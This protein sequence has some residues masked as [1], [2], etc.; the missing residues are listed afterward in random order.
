MSA[1]RTERAILPTSG[2]TVWLVVDDESLQPMPEARDFV[3][4]LVGA[5]RSENTIRAYIP[6]ITRFLNWAEASPDCDWRTVSVSQ[7]ARF[8]WFLEASPAR[9]NRRSS[10][11]K[12]DVAPRTVNASL[13][14][15][16]EFLRYCARAGHVPQTTVE[17]LVEPRYLSHMPRSFDGGERGEFRY[18]RV[19]V[20][21]AREIFSSPKRLT[22][23]Q[24]DALI[25]ATMHARDRF[26]VVLLNDT[27]LRI[28]EALGLRRS[29][30]HFLPDSTSLGC[31][32][33]GPHL[34]VVRRLDNPN[35]A[36]SKSR[37]N[38]RVPVGGD[39]VR[40]YRD[41]VV[42]R[43]RVTDA[44]WSDFVFVN[45]WAGQV[46]SPLTYHAAYKLIAR[47]ARR[48]GVV[49]M[50]PHLLRHTAA[51]RWIAEGVDRDVAQELLGHVSPSSTSVYT[52]PSDE[53]LRTAVDLGASALKEHP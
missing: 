38:R 15:V 9:A 36:S 27:G 19:K 48:A 37:H 51:S 13:T 20:L 6:R 12:Q 3:L 52:H 33:P 4:Y 25:N 7:L 34:H 29:D 16:I 5:D 28:G 26:L 47:L 35:H 24:V 44:S 39:L 2:R 49:A 53:R 14:A 10:R 18:A 11:A 1:F 31:E 40:A 46:G 50:H 30:M 17:R 41:Y 43:E 23:A 21:R 22:D 8:K 42:E 32:T 45:L